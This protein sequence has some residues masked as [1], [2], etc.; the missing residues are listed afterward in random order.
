MEAIRVIRDLGLSEEDGYAQEHTFHA[1]RS[2][3]AC[4]DDLE[5]ACADD[6]LFREAVTPLL[7]LY[8]ERLAELARAHSRVQPARRTPSGYRLK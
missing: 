6:V 1:F 7:D 4:L 2:L 5:A 8:R 3:R